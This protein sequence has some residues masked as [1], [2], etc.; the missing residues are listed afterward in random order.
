MLSVHRFH[1]LTSRGHPQLTR[2]ARSP[3]PLQNVSLEAEA[4]SVTHHSSS[5]HPTS[6]HTIQS[7][8]I[9]ACHTF[10]VSPC[11]FPCLFS[12]SSPA[13][14]P[15]FL[16]FGQLLNGPMSQLLAS[17]GRQALEARLEEFWNVW[18]SDWRRELESGELRSSSFP[19]L[20]SFPCPCLA[21]VDS[22]LT[23]LPIDFPRLQNLHLPPI[24]PRFL[25]LLLRYSSPII[26][27]S[28]RPQTSSPFPYYNT[29]QRSY[30]IHHL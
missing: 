29:Y 20:L 5:R 4:H 16:S 3:P 11:S 14:G 18:V 19:P 25:P 22:Q 28:T 12:P 27:P 17:S 26:T 8:L 21:R 13:D 2:T 7:S 9:R 6:L 15:S 23:L 1:S 30:L 24:S 10:T